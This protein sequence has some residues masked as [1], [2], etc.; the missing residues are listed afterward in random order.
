M[1]NDI[2]GTP[3]PDPLMR[4]TDYVQ[5]EYS[6][7]TGIAANKSIASGQLIKVK[8]LV[9]GLPDTKFPNM[10]GEDERIPYVADAERYSDG[11]KADANVPIK[12]QN[13]S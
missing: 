8:D 4:A 13:D 11:E 7:L 9:S 12:L 6:I 1:L 2:F 3:E 5:G 10:P